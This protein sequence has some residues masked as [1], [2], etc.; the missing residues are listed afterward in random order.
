MNRLLAPL[1]FVCLLPVGC[2]DEPELPALAAT[3]VILAFG[4][5]LTYGTGAKEEESYP[6]V[7]AHLTGHEVINAGVPG[8]ISAEGMARLGGV[9]DEYQPRLLLLCH[10]GNDMIRQMDFNAMENNLRGMITEAQERNIPIILL[11][12]PRPGLFLSAADVY[13]RVAEDT[14]VV[15]IEDLLPEILGDRA[16]KSDT[17]HPNKDGYRRMAEAIHQVFQDTGVL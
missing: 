10:G 2:G 5:S 4:D 1:L 16:L 11:G 6:A 12:V 3:D 13:G 7:L 17:V 9:L 14:G 15:Y 8:E